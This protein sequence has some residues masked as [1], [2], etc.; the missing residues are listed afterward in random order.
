MPSEALVAIAEESARVEIS[1]LWDTHQGVDGRFA[2]RPEAKD[3]MRASSSRI[4]ALPANAPAPRGPHPRT[5]GAT[6][7]HDGTVEGLLSAVHDAFMAHDAAADILAAANLQPRLGQTVVTVETSMEIALKVR[8]LVE[9][10]L[11]RRAF[12]CILSAAAADDPAKGTAI[13]RFIRLGMAKAGTGS[14]TRCPKKAT[15]TRACRAASGVKWMEDLAQPEV[16][17]VVALYRSVVNERHL[18][19]QFMRFEHCE[20]DVW[21]ARCNPKSSVVPLLMDWFIARF[22]DQRFVIYD[23]VHRVSGV[24]DGTGWYPVSGEEAVPPP[25]LE[26]ERVMRE[27]WQRFYRCIAIDARYNPE[28]RRSFMPMRLW[29]NLPELEPNP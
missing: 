6:Y 5:S 25:H 2:A 3:R 29:R 26:D 23:E 19:L 24:Y 16:H 27:A 1:G 10:D 17:A 15:C 4:D 11:G 21:F 20:G 28:L 8:R 22:N 13:Y 14:C 7:A 18:M 9:H 12:Q